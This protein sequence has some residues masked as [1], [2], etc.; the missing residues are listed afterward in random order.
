[1]LLFFCGTFFEGACCVSPP[2]PLGSPGFHVHPPP[3]PLQVANVQDKLRQ[4]NV[5][6]LAWKPDY[7]CF[8]VEE[9]RERRQLVAQL[10]AD[11]TEEGRAEG[12]TAGW[13]GNMRS[14]FFAHVLHIL[15]IFPPDGALA[16]DRTVFFVSPVKKTCCL[17]VFHCICS[18]CD[19]SSRH[20]C[21]H[22]MLNQIALILITG[23]E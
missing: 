19:V 20:I 18:F 11:G 23:F 4:L 3:P 7:E 22:V 1:M 21:N 13:E 17:S 8:T 12:D 16:L 2:P 9:E 6:G 5:P 14:T 15:H 10:I